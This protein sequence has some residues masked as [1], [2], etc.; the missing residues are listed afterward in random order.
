MLSIPKQVKN[1]IG[2][3]ILFASIGAA[4][5]FF[6]MLSKPKIYS[7]GAEIVVYPSGSSVIQPHNLEVEAMNTVRIISQPAFVKNFINHSG[8]F[9][10]FAEAVGESSVI[11]VELKAQKERLEDAEDI[12]V[13]LPQILTQYERDLYGGTPFS[14]KLLAD[15]YR[16]N[17]PV[18]PK[19]LT[20]LVAGAAAGILMFLII[21]I[22]WPS[23]VELKIWKNRQFD[24]SSISSS[25][26]IAN[27][28][29]PAVKEKLTDESYNKGKSDK[30][31]LMGSEDH[32]FGNISN[33]KHNHS[34]LSSKKNALEFSRSDQSEEISEILGEASADVSDEELKKK[35]NRLISE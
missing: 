3:A 15:P 27:D 28:F 1:T 2:L 19:I 32:S 23:G 16:L 31:N 11:K 7:V 9:F 12:L 34:L 14:Y 4:I 13:S 8:E 6:A 10:R 20:Y 30:I 21:W 5:G 35:L 25:I 24:S 33:F 29:K 22:I 17:K 18:E 26:S